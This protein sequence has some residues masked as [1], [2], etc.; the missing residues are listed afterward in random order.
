MSLISPT[1][2]NSLM[3]KG[4]KGVGEPFPVS[5]VILFYN[6]IC[7]YFSFRI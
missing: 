1:N 7:C 5:V 3:I 4:F 2:N 6:E